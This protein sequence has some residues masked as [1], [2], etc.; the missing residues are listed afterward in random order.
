[1]LEVCSDDLHGLHDRAL[2]LLAYDPI[3]RRSELL[4]LRVAGM[5][6]APQGSLTVLL[7]KSKTDQHFIGRF[8]YLS[9]QFNL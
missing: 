7:R 6:S 8:I 3:K 1:M 9:K 2:L 5:K 4:T